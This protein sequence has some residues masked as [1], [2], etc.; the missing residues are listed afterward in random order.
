VAGQGDE[1]GH[2]TFPLPDTGQNPAIPIPPDANWRDQGA[3]GLGPPDAPALSGNSAPLPVETFEPFESFTVPDLGTNAHVGSASNAVPPASPPPAVSPTRRTR[4]M[5]IAIA[6]LAV[7]IAGA[8]WYV[9][10]TAKEVVPRGR[11]SAAVA[12]PR[13]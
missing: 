3:V 6:L 11:D 12:T 1:V 2:N 8:A 7:L 10:R 4:G 5:A 13:A 9:W